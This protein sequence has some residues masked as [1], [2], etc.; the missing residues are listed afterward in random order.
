MLR[1]IAL[2]ISSFASL[3]VLQPERWRKYA[4]TTKGTLY[5]DTV[6]LRGIGDSVVEVWVKQVR[7]AP[8][9]DSVY[10][11]TSQRLI[12]YVVAE[13]KTLYEISCRARTFM[14]REWTVTS[15]EGNAVY[16]YSFP[17]RQAIPYQPETV[18]EYL[19]DA[20]CKP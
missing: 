17:D 13:E 6:S 20:V 5:F 1:T 18:M 11:P 19:A 7:K 2:L 4:T 12:R 10:D 15:P 3:Y 8:A 16:S 14:P 9:L